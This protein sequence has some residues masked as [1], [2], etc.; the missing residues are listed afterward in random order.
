MSPADRIRLRHLVDAADAAAEF[1]RGRSRTDLDTDRMLLF[2][3]VRA[4]EVLGEAASK[5]SEEGRSGLNLPWIAIVGMR[6]R[7]VHAYFDVDRD[8]LWATVQDSLPKLRAM[9]AAALEAH[10]GE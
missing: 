7:L 9:V 8:V 4:V 1:V 6:N 2:A 10:P 3:L 5:V